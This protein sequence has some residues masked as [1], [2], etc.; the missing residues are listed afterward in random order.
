MMAALHHAV[1]DARRRAFMA[2]AR[3][4]LSAI[5]D[6]QQAQS[7]QLDLLDGETA[8]GIERFQNY[9]LTSVP[10]PD[11]EAVMVSVGGLRSHGIVVAVEDRRYRLVGLAAGE[12]ALY[13]DQG[14]VAHLTRDGILISSPLKVSIHS[15]A[16]VDVTAPKVV[17]TSDDVELG[18][19]GGQAVARVGDTV[20]LGAGTISSGSAKV[21]C[22]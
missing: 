14:Q 21:T 15:D 5:D 10:F 8:D 1:K 13:D 12:V 18:A 20:D 4:V 7:L 16:E 17:I 19:T 9:G 2:V 11:A 3:G 22:G 6:T